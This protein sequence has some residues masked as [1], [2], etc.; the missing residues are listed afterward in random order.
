[1]RENQFL[2]IRVRSA[3]NTVEY[4]CLLNPLFPGFHNLIKIISVQE[5]MIDERLV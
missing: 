3:V 5:I 4:N 2:G 1:M